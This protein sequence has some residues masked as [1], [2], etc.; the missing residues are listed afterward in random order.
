LKDDIAVID[1]ESETKDLKDLSEVPAVDSIVYQTVLDQ[2]K[3]TAAL[4]H[5]M[6]EL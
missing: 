4:L 1:K 2:Y 6:K 5:A 3:D